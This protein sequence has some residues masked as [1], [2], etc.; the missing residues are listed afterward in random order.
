MCTLHINHTQNH[1]NSNSVLVY[2]ISNNVVSCHRLP[3]RYIYTNCYVKLLHV[4]VDQQTTAHSIFIELIVYFPFPLICMA[5]MLFTFF[6]LFLFIFIRITPKLVHSM[7]YYF[8]RSKI[9]RYVCSLTHIFSHLVGLFIQQFILVYCY[10]AQ[11]MNKHNFAPFLV[12]FFTITPHIYI[13]SVPQP[14]PF[15]HVTGCL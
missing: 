2:H 6:F 8:L 14:I 1:F 10:F 11:C 13:L 4:V 3:L 7:Q 9:L 12:V 5:F 15:K